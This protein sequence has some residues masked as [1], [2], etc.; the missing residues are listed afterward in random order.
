MGSIHD[1]VSTKEVG[2]AGHLH[3]DAYERRSGLVHLF[4]PGTTPAAFGRADA[5]EYGD[6]VAGPFIVEATGTDEG[7]SWARMARDGVACTPDAALPI[8]V[9]K[10]LTAGGDR[11][12]PTLSL[13]VRV[14]NRGAGPLE[15]TLAVEW[16]LTM[17]GGGGN[18]AAYYLLDGERIPH[19]GSAS[20]ASLAALHSGN[21]YVGID[22][23]TRA[24]PPAAAWISSIDTVSSS[25]AGFERVYQGSALVL[26]WPLVLEPGASIAVRVEQ[27]VATSRDRAAEEAAAARTVTR[28]RLAIHAHLYQ[29]ERRDPFGGPSRLDPT[30]APFPSWNARISAECYRPNAER[31]NLDHITFDVGPTLTGWMAAEDPDVLA[32]IAAAD[33]GAN[34]VAQGYH[35]VILPLAS[36]R[37]RRTEICWGLR[38]FALRF[39]RP[40]AGFW[41]PET[42]VDR[43]VLRVLA[44]EGIRWT[45]LAPWQASTPGLET[46]RPHRVEL[47]GGREL[48]VAFYDAGLSGDVSFQPE[49][50]ADADRF[51]REWALPLMTAPLHRDGSLRR[52]PGTPLVVVATDGELYGHHQRWRDLFLQRLVDPAMDRGFDVVTL[53]SELAA[54]DPA[55]LPVAAIA[56]RTSWSCHHGVLRWSAECPC[57]PDG[58]WKQP[59]RAAL[60]RLAGAIDT[61][62]EQ[63]AAAIPAVGGASAAGG[64]EAGDRAAPLDRARP[65]DPWAARDD[66]VEVVL[67]QATA[68]AFS[69]RLLG[70][71]APNAERR[72]TEV[73]LEAQRWRLA[74][75]ASD[76]W[77][78]EE[79]SRPET[80][81]ALRSAARAARLVD[82]LAGT[83][84]ERRLV[85]DLAL[86]AVAS[87]RDQRRR[88]LPGG[89][90]RGRPGPGLTIERRPTRNDGG[91]RSPPSLAFALGFQQR[92]CPRWCS[93]SRV[94]VRAPSPPGPSTSP[95]VC[96]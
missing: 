56:D 90:R 74:M 25:E 79:P 78:W 10:T 85:D 33:H 36:A 89:A 32:R 8:R 95:G 76:A 68:A 72:E 63:R 82:G 43:H 66:Y 45:I 65:L 19:D 67:G 16:A 87:P 20:R 84:L 50:T 49:V 35:H 91:D 28:G 34:A 24:R 21:E 81:Q 77:Y 41:L 2:L 6:F 7:G 88:D 52:E 57:T 5:S 64:V 46:R 47:G 12:T 1:R 13:D 94:E 14:E 39:G 30:S 73:L 29:P 55:A 75:F 83:R 69:A 51:A 93:T 42:A 70:E 86:L 92:S 17:L 9:V 71:G 60:E 59:L 31:G 11:R 53:G 23:E 40:A 37:D 15:A 4:A 18:P 58:R 22:I 38:D 27:I 62:T 26:A 44:E 96:R 61:I 80:K 48:I 3:Y 54:E